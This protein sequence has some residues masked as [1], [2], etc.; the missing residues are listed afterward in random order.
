LLKEFSKRALQYQSNVV[1]SLGPTLKGKCLDGAQIEFP[2]MFNYPNHT[3]FPY[4][5][6][7][8]FLHIKTKTID[9]RF[10]ISFTFTEFLNSKSEF[11]EIE[12]EEVKGFAYKVG[13]NGLARDLGGFEVFLFFF[14]TF[15]RMEQKT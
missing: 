1:L 10:D 2:P 8:L 9:E 11:K 7:D 14:F 15:F 4:T 13:S 5:G 6:G 3:V 12:F